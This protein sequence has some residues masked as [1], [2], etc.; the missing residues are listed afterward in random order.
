MPSSFGMLRNVR[1]MRS[2]SASASRQPQ[3]GDADNRR[4]R[5]RKGAPKAR[6]Y[7][8]RANALESIRDGSVSTHKGNLYEVEIPEE[9]EYLLWDKPLSEQPA[10]VRRA[11]KRDSR[12]G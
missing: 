3:D 11:L 10:K 2:K 9:G 8:E 7:A 5:C 1:L 12:A 6:Y 4:Q